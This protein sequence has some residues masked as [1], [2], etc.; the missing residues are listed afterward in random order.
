MAMNKFIQ[1]SVGADKSALRG[2]FH[3][4]IIYLMYM[5]ASHATSVLEKVE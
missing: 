2:C 3:I 1:P 5:R 4:W